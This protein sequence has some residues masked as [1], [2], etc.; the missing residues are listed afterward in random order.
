MTVPP[1]VPVPHE[2]IRGRMSNARSLPSRLAHTALLLVALGGVA[3]LATLLSTEQALPAPTRIALLVLLLMCVA[4]SAFAT[5]VLARRQVLYAQQLVV[6][7]RM[8]IAFSVVFTVG[9]ALVGAQQGSGAAWML[10]PTV[11]IVMLLLAVVRLRR[12]NGRVAALVRRRAEL[13]Q[14]LRSGA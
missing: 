9:S 13:E 11:G 1:A 7:A 5:W 12:A 8:A 3:L 4:W 10:A 14:A 6:A 2:V